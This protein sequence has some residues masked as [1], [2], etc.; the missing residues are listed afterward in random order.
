MINVAIAVLFF[1][2]SLSGVSH[3]GTFFFWNSENQACGSVF[4]F[5]A[6][7]TPGREGRIACGQTPRGE[8]Y[9]EWRTQDF[10]NQTLTEMED[11]QG[12]PVAVIPGKTYYLAFYFNFTRIDGKD[13]WHEVGFPDS[14]FDKAYEFVGGGVRWIIFFGQLESA[15][16]ARN[17]DHK[18]TA[19]IT[20]GF[21]HLNPQIECIDQ[22][23][24]NSAGFSEANPMQLDYETWH[25][26]VMAIK[27]ASDNTG[28]AG[29]YIDGINILQYNNIKT[30]APGSPTISIIKMGGTIAQPEYDAPAHIRKFDD[31]ILTDDLQEIIDGGYLGG[32]DLIAP[33]PPS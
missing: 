24:Q 9:L 28:S 25:T 31:L 21:Y 33:A 8:K 4:P 13:I 26:G 2:L 10:W 16:F 5:P 20:N 18:F 30:Y 32:P 22:L 12:L 23:V 1:L 7:D 3:A 17:Q 29:L 15:C 11:T 27:M 19:W 6:V 14:S